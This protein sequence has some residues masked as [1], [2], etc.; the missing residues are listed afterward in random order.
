MSF[1]ATTL[2]FRASNKDIRKTGLFLPVLM[3]LY[4]I[5]GPARPVASSPTFP[6]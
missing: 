1:S 6:E 2:I 4:V 3:S 5:G